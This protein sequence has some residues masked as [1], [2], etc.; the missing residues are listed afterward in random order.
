MTSPITDSINEKIS[1]LPQK[2][3]DKYEAFAKLTNKEKEEYLKNM[4]K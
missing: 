2:E 4:M 3:R 1:K